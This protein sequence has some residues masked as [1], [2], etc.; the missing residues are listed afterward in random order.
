[1]TMLRAILILATMASV[2]VGHYYPEGWNTWTDGRGD[3]VIS[4]NGW[5]GWNGWNNGVNTWTDGRGDVV[6][7]RNS[8]WNGPRGFAGGYGYGPYGY[9]NWNNNGWNTWSDG[10]GDVV[11]VRNNWNGW[12]GYYNN[13]NGIRPWIGYYSNRAV[14]DV[15]YDNYAPTY[16]N[17]Y[18]SHW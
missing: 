6:S 12:N 8:Y 15:V 16:A 18:Y 14:S 9:N 11:S 5:N 2:A 3:Y 17:S 7:V 4:R 1:M 13:W 10:R